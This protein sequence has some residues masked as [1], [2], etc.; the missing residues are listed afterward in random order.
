MKPAR[1]AILTLM[2]FLLPMA[3]S[4]AGTVKLKHIQTLYADAV[5]KPMNGPSAVTVKEDAVVVTD[6]DN[7]RL[8]RFT[9]KDGVVT[10]GAT[11][12]VDRI[13]PIKV[14]IGSNG[15]LFVLD[16]KDRRIVRLGADGALKGNLDIKGAVS[17]K[18]VPRSLRITAD[19][20]IAILDIFSERVLWVDESGVVQG[21][22]PF[23]ADYGFIS[24]LSVDRQGNVFLIDSVTA[25]V[26]LAK[27]GEDSF[28]RLTGS[29]KEHMNFPSTL[30][31]DNQGHIYL[32]DQ[33]GSGLAVIGIDGS[34]LGR[35]L[36]MG[37][38]DS[39]LFYPE[40]MSISDQ[41]DVFIADRENNRVQQFLVVE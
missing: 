7:R 37:W 35:K 41:G 33:Y 39:Q 29:L 22:L 31:V 40:G 13:Y 8:L 18:V 11:L 26:Y 10:P 36:G 24:D 23:P 12:P 15:E 6:S 19:G 38:N 30:E 4:A 14:Q 25:V 27:K 3:A 21:Q 9:L 28:A 1:I 32:V 16:G 17:G 2:L 20:K 34:F 5:G